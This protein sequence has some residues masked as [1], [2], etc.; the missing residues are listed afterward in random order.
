VRKNLERIEPVEQASPGQWK[1]PLGEMGILRIAEAAGI[2][3]L[4]PSTIRAWI[5]KRR[6]PY[7]K[8][9]G[10]VCLRRAD[11]EALI[12]QSLVPAASTAQHGLKSAG[13]SPPQR[14]EDPNG[15]GK[16]ASGGGR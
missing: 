15:E 6:I 4:Q 16:P 9:G 3:R 2:L 13:T 12:E 1:Q 10:R 11:L 14:D 8:L 5:L 7:L